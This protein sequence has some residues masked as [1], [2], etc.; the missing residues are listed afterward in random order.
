MKS[1]AG[2]KHYRFRRSMAVR[3]IGAI[4]LLLMLFVLIS[5]VIGLMNFTN[6]IKNV[7]ST[8]TYHMADTAAMLVNGDNLDAYLAGD[9]PAEYQRTKNIL[10]TYCHRIY[11][12]MIYVIQVD[13]SDYGR[14]VSIFNPVYNEV[15]DSEYTEWELGHRR[16]TT[17][18]EYRQ[19]Y[20]AIY[21][22][23][24][25]YETVYRIKTTDG[26]HPHIT[27]MVPVKNSAGDVAAIL[28][29]QRPVREI[30]DARKP[31][32]TKIALSAVMV[33][34]LASALAAV[35]IQKS[36]VDP[37]GKVS[38][39]ASRFA[40]ENTLGTPLGT[41]SRIEEIADLALSIDTMEKDMVNYIHNLTQVTAEKQ[42][43]STELALAA[44]IQADMLPNTFPAF[45]GRPEFD[46]Y[47]SMAPAKEV[48][49]DFY[50]F[51]L[52][53]DD[54]LCL[55]IADVSGKGIPAALFMMASKIILQ[56]NAMRG[57]PPADI[58]SRTNAAVCANNRE[59]MFITVWLG[60]LEISTGKL[61]AANAGH[62]Y[63][64]IRRAGESFALLRDPHSFVLGGMPD[65]EY[66]QY[67]LQ[68]RRGDTLFLYTDGVPEA[69]DARERMFGTDGMLAALNSSPD[70]SPRQLLNAVRSAADDFVQEA[71]QFDDLTML[72]VE[73][74]GPSR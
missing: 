59:E 64:A 38:A 58:L 71:E 57:Y 52:S 15:D 21:E 22:Q 10:D 68:L 23:G 56:N 17:N 42:R 62:E 35:Y 26:Q 7:Y 12:S 41:I 55:V 13:Q 60:I 72:C 65:M 34:I 9:M 8:S 20:K 69:T 40:R 61:T 67:E 30:N 63:P 29:M 37:I 27:T 28:C 74:R 50:E 4:V 54:H 14:F 39:E 33:A 49:G 18:D 51:F 45:P 66:G 73:Y 24:S 31:F 19:K 70:A 6:A 36:F 1:S 25:A 46:I 16:D 5:S 3:F 11:V 43:I 32:L 44:R 53:D 48:G 2:K 47:A